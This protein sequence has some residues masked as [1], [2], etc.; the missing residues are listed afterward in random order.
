MV[1]CSE[2]KFPLDK[3]QGSF[4]SL[5]S[6]GISEIKLSGISSEAEAMPF[7]AR[8]IGGGQRKRQPLRLPLL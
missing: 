7:K 2:R 3:I 4:A 6:G 5:R 8:T 1:G